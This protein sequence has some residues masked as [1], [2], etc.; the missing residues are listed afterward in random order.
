[1]TRKK[2][3]GAPKSACDMP[4]TTCPTVSQNGT[5]LE[6]ALAAG[7]EKRAD[8]A[9]AQSAANYSHGGGKKKK[10]GGQ[11]VVPQPPH[12]GPSAGGSSSAKNYAAGIH[13]AMTHHAQSKYDKEANALDTSPPKSP[14]GGGKKKRRKRRRKTRGKTQRKS[15]ISKRRKTRRK[16]KSRRKRKKTRKHRS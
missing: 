10:G 12:T 16:I 7:H 11:V 8:A 14:F 15:R 9:E 6:A 2:R 13:S 4:G 3:G 1:M 5:S